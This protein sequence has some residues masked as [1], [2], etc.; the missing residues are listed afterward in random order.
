MQ[1]FT[2]HAELLP[3]TEQIVFH[4]A[5][6]YGQVRRIIV[7]I[8]NLEKIDAEILKSKLSISDFRKYQ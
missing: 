3:H 2:F 5:G 7:D 1:Y 6:V 4:K 8:K